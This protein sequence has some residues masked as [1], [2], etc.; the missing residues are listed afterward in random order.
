MENRFRGLFLSLLLVAFSS[1]VFAAE[2][3]AE[4]SEQAA[5]IQPE[6]ERQPFDEALINADDFE[7][8][9]AAGYLS[10]E[11][12]GVNPLLVLKLNYHVNEDIFIQLGYGQS[13]TGKTSYEVLSG[14]APL[15][16]SAERELS[17]YSVNIGY[18]VL[19]GEAFLTES[20]TYNNAFYLTAGIGVTD[21]AGDD[22]FTI[23][24]GAGYRLLFTDSFAF[25]A[26]FRNNQFDMDVFGENRATSNL[27]YTFGV[28]WIF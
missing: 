1:T 3:A 7:L 8:L 22:R 26:D 4:S 13:N 15:L 25:Y 20:T 28:S 16:T 2:P 18:N 14:G 11:D 5:L 10:V 27:E 6:V 19:P 12:F 21:F 23:N 17:Y 24:Y 9:L